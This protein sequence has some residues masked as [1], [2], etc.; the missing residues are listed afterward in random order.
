MY[1]D[2]QGGVVVEYVFGRDFTGKGFICCAKNRRMLKLN[3]KWEQ[4]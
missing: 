1:S 2:M 3:I 4:L